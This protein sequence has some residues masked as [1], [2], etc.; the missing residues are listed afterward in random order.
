MIVLFLNHKIID[1]GVYQYG[2]RMYNILKKSE[3]HIYIYK[4]I[5]SYYEYINYINSIEHH[6]IIYNYHS[7]TMSWLNSLNIQKR[8][9]N[10]VIPHESDF[11]IFDF[12]LSIDPNEYEVNNIYNIPRPIYENI[13]EIKEN[14]QIK[15]LNTKNFIDYNEGENIPIFGS[16]GFGTLSKGFDKIVKLI[17]DNYEKAI[18]K[19]VITI[20][21]FDSDINR[22]TNSSKISNL[23]NSLNTNPNIKLLITH[24]FFTNEEI[25]LFLSSNDAN[26][27]LYDYM[28]GRGISSVIDY[29]ISAQK[30]IVISDSY[31]FRHIYSDDICVY[32]T[33]INEAIDYSQNILPLII[34]KFSNEN[35]INKIDSIIEI[36]S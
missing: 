22:I 20:P 15:N 6:I 5:D 27:F 4:E 16:F 13:K 10:V 32:K 26:I 23:C 34:N 3:K 8:V 31:M 35:L 11:S 2:Y 1:C 36:T 33:R 12:I 24:D 7:V 29:A 19:L 30:P 21:Y 14:Y 25:L 9:K 28:H 18:I 17:N